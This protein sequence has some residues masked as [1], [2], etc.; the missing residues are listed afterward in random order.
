MAAVPK[1]EAIDKHPRWRK[2]NVTSVIVNMTWI[3][4][5]SLAMVSTSNLQHIFP[6]LNVCLIVSRFLK[7]LKSRQLGRARR[8]SWC[9]ISSS[10]HFKCHNWFRSYK[11]LGLIWRLMVVKCHI[12]YIFKSFSNP[13]FH[14]IKTKPKQFNL[15]YFFA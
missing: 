4:T 15:S 8:F 10:G 12:S 13:Q 2:K 9:K 6:N 11:I 14:F 7:R 5:T 1:E 3:L